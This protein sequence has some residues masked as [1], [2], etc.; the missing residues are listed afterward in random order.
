MGSRNRPSSDA[1]LVQ[2]TDAESNSPVGL[3]TTFSAGGFTAQHVRVN[4]R[5][6]YTFEW[7]GDPHY[8]ALHDLHRKDGETFA[9]D[10]CAATQRDL[11][12]RL[13]FV[14]SG[15]RVW[16]WLVPSPRP[17]SFTA[18]CLD[19]ARLEHELAARIRRVPQRAQ[20]YFCNTALRSTLEKL[21]SCLLSQTPPDKLYAESLCMLTA[22]ELCQLPREEDYEAGAP[23]GRFTDRVVEYME[24]NLSQD[25][26]LEDLSRVAG[27]S[28]FHF[29]RAF[30]RATHE[31]PYRHLLRRRV[32]RAQELLRS[33]DLSIAEIALQVGFKNST[34]F[35]VAF[36]RM[37]NCTP[38]AFRAAVRG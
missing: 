2:L 3:F 10:E 19:S 15:C 23:G 28:R 33:G 12:G 14:P 5:E 6:G 24:Q 8:V 21:R 29:L 27:L 18:L 4:T 22:L 30:R 32:E 1:A 35:T 36:R 11:R 13:T 17:Q 20:L 34:R 26:S 9:D 37:T 25:L 16:G 7:H 38:S 31:T